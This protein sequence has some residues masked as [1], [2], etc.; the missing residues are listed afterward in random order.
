MLLLWEGDHTSGLF[1]SL[2]EIVYLLQQI[3]LGL[4]IPVQMTQT[5]GLAV[6]WSRTVGLQPS[7]TTAVHCSVSLKHWGVF[8]EPI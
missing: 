6:F 5:R 2:E 3:Q 8:T 1:Y 7:R 4:V